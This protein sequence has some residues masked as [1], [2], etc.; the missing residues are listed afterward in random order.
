MTEKSPSLL[1]AKEELDYMVK[2]G[3]LDYDSK[4]KAYINSLFSRKIF[5]VKLQD[6]ISKFR[7][8]IEEEIR[9]QTLAEVEKI[10]DKAI[11]NF[12]T[13]F[14]ITDNA[15]IAEVRMNAITFIFRAKEE[16]KNLKSQDGVKSSGV[17]GTRFGHPDT[18][19]KDK[20]KDD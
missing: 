13:T 3:L 8:S 10:I 9:K 14:Y 2:I 5:K 12:K 6:D 7:G 16:I 4:K 1:E 11:N 15:Y 20:V 18:H 19:S 17:S